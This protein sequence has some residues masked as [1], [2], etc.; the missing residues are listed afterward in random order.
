MADTVS[1]PSAASQLLQQHIA[2]DSHRVTIEDAEDE[3]LHKPVASADASTS[4]P[5]PSWVE[6]I[7]TKAA[8]KQKA[9]E[10]TGLDT[11][12]HELFPELGGPKAKATAGVA[13]I[14]SA[15]TNV[16]GKTNGTSPVNGTPRTSAPASG[17]TTP[18]GPGLHGPPS[19]S[20]PG[21]N[22]ETL[23]LEP[24]HVLARNQ[25]KRPL[26]DILKDLNRKS[27]ANINMSTLGNG[28]LKFEASGPQDLALQAL[29]DLVN[30]IGTKQSVKVSIPHSARAHIIGKGGST[31]KSLQEKS[32]ARIQL[33]KVEDNQTPADDDEDGTIDVL[34]EGNA[35]SA[36]TA[37]DAILKIAGERAANVN[38]RVKGI[39]AEFY[40]FIAG[41]KNSLVHKLE[42]DNGVQIRV[43]PHQA[44]S[45]QPPSVPAPG[46]NPVFIPAQN[47]NHIQLAGERA[48]VQAAR[49][50]IE[51]HVEELRRKLA[52]EQ[53]SIQRG[54]HQFI[55]GDR[56][57]PMDQF[58]ED[59]GCAIILPND[60]EDDS[61]T[62]VGPPDHIQAGLDRAMDLAM[63]M[64]CSNIDISRFHRQAPGGAAA[65]ARNVTRYLRQRKEIERLEKMYNVHFNTPFTEEG[66]LPW[67]LYSRDGKNA[68]RAQ[69][70]IK[71]L[72]DS[73]PPARMANVAVD[74]FFHSYI[75][76]EVQPRVRQDYRVHLVVPEASEANAPLL[77]VYEGPSSP[78]SYQ[79]PRSQPSQ[80]D[81]S[82]MQKFLQ[83]ARAHIRDLVSQQE[84]LTSASLDVPQKFH[85]KLRKFI[86]KEQE[87]RAANKIP[88]RVSSLG[89]TVNI[90][91]PS[92]AVESLA[93]KCEAFIEQEKADEKE[94]GFILEF[95]F[96]QKFAN[97]LIGKGGSNIREL[98]EKFDVDIQV[99]DGKVELKGPKAKAEVAKAHILALGRQLQDET[100]HILKIDPKF[101]RELIGAQG[102]QI[103]RLQTRY[104]VLIFFPRTA[105]TAKDDDSAEATSDAG[106]PRRQQAPDEVIVRGP[107]KG[108]DEARDELL[109]LLQ[110]LRDN[111]FGAT[112]SVQQ[113]QV[114]SLIGSGGAV[115]DQLR[116]ATGAKIDVPSSREATDGLVEIQIKGTKT[117]V[118]AAKKLLEEKKAIYDDTVT[119]TIDVDRKYHKTLIG[120]GGS[121]LRDIV[122]K[123]GGSDDRRE[124][125]RAIQFPKQDA[126][127]STIKVE[128]R[129]DVVDKII[130]QIQ[131]FVSE[132]DSQVTEVLEVPQEKH[133]SLIGRGGDVKRGLE[134]QFKVSIDIP[135]QGSSQTGVKIV[136]QST[137][138][139]KAKAHIETLIKEQQGETVQI[140]RAFHHAIA[141]NGQ[142]FRKL[143]SD[144]HV[145]VDHAGHAIPAKPVVS[146]NTRVDGGALPLI[147]DD[148]EAIADVHSWNVVEQTSAEEGEIPWVLRGSAENIEKA[149]KVIDFALE[150]AKKQTATGYLILPDPKTYRYVI[151]QG[152]SKVNAIRKQSGCKITVPRDQA[153]GEA[154]EVVGS[155]EG[156][157]KAK[158][159]I[160]VAVREGVNSS[161]QPRD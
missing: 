127:G 30:Q 51:R 154:I 97:H 25:L 87:N 96:P 68:I 135:R 122:V 61:V 134:S 78:E 32:G 150:Q 156:V 53:L 67:E 102:G 126:D 79:I 8:G 125:A 110:Y 128:G 106:K 81:V 151:G 18:T 83:E 46:Q 149:K 3:E 82:E 54:R 69:S 6:P 141:N 64:Q 76:N 103:N 21:R 7:S 74:P 55:I 123:A 121:N 38:T 118:A 31:I 16:N 112:I 105:K 148:A 142:I 45:S 36:A 161:K 56:G 137:D 70:E 50:E 153:K 99:H 66:A 88:V 100:T 140:P 27:R 159:L 91:G 52:L 114:P 47:D 132:R 39:P 109:S 49:A 139:E 80:A 71:G 48:A 10:P 144:N 60:E 93:A 11:Q 131:S 73:H 2:A 19:L 98:R 160:L 22:V 133:R 115:L 41:P 44:W 104:K 34:I 4:E 58:F 33:P 65:H 86:K 35:L 108:A 15:K 13:P 24:Q 1:E 40:P 43:P 42:E 23:F 94:R 116:Q 130:A 77:L 72:V 146:D 59:T 157:E 113:K 26:P 143:K 20:I 90:R 57:I 101:H 89:T 85:D 117:Q 129:T 84:A 92:S 17:V 147:T 155:K 63:N 119:K 62:I 107:K 138:V 145:T 95:E 124:L 9:Q 75:R 120:A 29:K 5:K 28:K 14:W 152:G 37:R 158:E 136:G 111:S 12:S